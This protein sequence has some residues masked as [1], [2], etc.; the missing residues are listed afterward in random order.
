MIWHSA[1]INDISSELKVDP[2]KGLTD[3]EAS[4]RLEQYGE[5]YSFDMKLSSIKSLIIGHLKRPLVIVLILAAAVFGFVE[6]MLPTQSENPWLEVMIILLITAATV[7]IGVLREYLS[8]KYISESQKKSL[9]KVAVYRSGKGKM[10]SSDKIVPGDIIALKQGCCIPADARLIL[11]DNLTCNESAITDDSAPVVKDSDFVSEDITPVAERANMV[12]SGCWVTH[13]TGLAIVVE[14]GTHTE[15]GKLTYIS[16]HDAVSTAK[17]GLSNLSSFINRVSPI[18][19]VLLYII[20]FLFMRFS[21]AKD[22]FLLNIASNDLIM[23]IALAFAV[24]PAWMHEISS[25]S[26]AIGIKRLSDQ[27]VAVT[28][29]DSIDKLG[30]VNV[31]CADKTAFMQNNMQ[32]VS[33]YNGRDM[34]NMNGAVSA[35]AITLIK[36][37]A[38]C[39]DNEKDPTD[40]ALI[41]ACKDYARIDKKELGNLYP[42]LSNIPFDS[43]NMMM[44]SV[45]M[46]DGTPYAIV[47]GAAEAV[48]PRCDVN[49]AANLLN[50]AEAMGKEALHVIAV[51][52]KPMDN[53]SSTV[54]PTDE[55][56]ESGMTFLGLIGLADAP[57]NGVVQAVHQCRSAGIRVAMVT[58]DSINTATAIA[59]QVGI[60][61]DESEA[62]SSDEIMAMDNET[63]VENIGKYT[64]FARVSPESRKRI[65]TAMQASGMSVVATGRNPSDT[66]AIRAADV[67]CAFG[68]NSSSVARSV[69]DVII[70]DDSFLSLVTLIC[71]GHNIFENIRSAI[72]SALCCSISLI[73]AEFI[74]FFIWHTAILNPEQLLAAAMI[75][76]LFPCIAFAFEPYS[77]LDKTRRHKRIDDYFDGGRGLEIIWN[78]LMLGITV[79]VAYAFGS[80]IGSALASTMAFVTAVTANTMF[81]L[82][83][84]SRSAVFKVGLISNL[85]CI[86]SVCFT[87]ALMLLMLFVP[88]IGLASIT[89]NQLI[90]VI[91]LAVI[92]PVAGEIGKIIKKNFNKEK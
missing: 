88:N 60:L 44:V 7:S 79:M 14:T 16:N 91:I 32:V 19:F 43:Q 74:G 66:S 76:N 1:S 81:T 58:G 50:H 64:V 31:I 51:A 63:L 12:Y 83:L 36:L 89:T 35:D 38:A 82:S 48:I 65:I 78:G 20:A 68:R 25:V 15:T 39:S 42:R 21:S 75:V 2:K 37:T 49:D 85:F 24:S 23:T 33:I 62:I 18:V 26:T 46:I 28:N 77:T 86:A 73:I 11:S 90:V 67:G 22:S 70:E 8:C 59:R 30:Y 52:I 84:R 61:L 53:V 57:K 87:L 3:A 55:E 71:G 17:Q 92:A 69:A 56:L 40:S 6:Y 72:H 45:N 41:T 80:S 34:I 13:G 5:N 47:K 27:N 9:Y 54:N 29:V 10:V 4:L